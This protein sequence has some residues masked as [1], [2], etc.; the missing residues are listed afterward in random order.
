MNSQD[1]LDQQLKRAICYDNTIQLTKI[2]QL[3]EQGANCR[4]SND[5]L[6]N[7]ACQDGNV[8]VAKYLLEKGCAI[9]NKT[10]D[11]L[12][13]AVSSNKVELVKHLVENGADIFVAQN[14]AIKSAMRYNFLDIIIYFLEQGADIKLLKNFSKKETIDDVKNYMSKKQLAEKLDN[15]LNIAQHSSKIKI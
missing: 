13:F 7:I 6:L 2:K 15:T 10:G 4:Q 3:I 14:H 12:V 9:N 5:F 1:S 11:T 8:E